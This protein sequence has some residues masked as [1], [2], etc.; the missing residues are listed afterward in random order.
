M[1][2]QRE[3]A[4]QMNNSAWF[5]KRWIMVV[6]KVIVHEKL[7]LLEPYIIGDQCSE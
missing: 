2:L 6:G 5:I 4:N 7:K 3:K 1:L